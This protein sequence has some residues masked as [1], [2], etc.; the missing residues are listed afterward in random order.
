MDTYSLFSDIATV[1]VNLRN[2]LRTVRNQYER[3]WEASIMRT[4]DD[5]VKLKSKY[6]KTVTRFVHEY[7]TDVNEFFKKTFPH[8]LKYEARIIPDLEKIF[9]ETK[10]GGRKF[11]KVLQRWY[12]EPHLEESPADILESMACDDKENRTV[13]TVLPMFVSK[14]IADEKNTATLRAL[15]NDEEGAEAIYT[16]ITLLE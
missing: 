15:K 13:M 16:K 3:T 6:P 8:F 9:K 12:P 14:F 4:V 7:T 11:E 10:K 2:A 5:W 1:E